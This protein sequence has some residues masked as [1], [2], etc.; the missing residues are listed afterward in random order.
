MLASEL[1]KSKYRDYLDS[2]PFNIISLSA[3]RVFPRL[4]ESLK[5]VL[6]D[7][8][9]EIQK[10]EIDSCFEYYS[11]IVSSNLYSLY[12]MDMSQVALKSVIERADL[13]HIKEV[14][15]VQHMSTNS[16]STNYVVLLKDHLHICIWLLLFSEGIVCQHFFQIMLKSNNAIFSVSLIKSYWYQRNT[17]L[18][19]VDALFSHS[20]V[21]NETMM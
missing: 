2:L 19:N 7:R 1:Q 14:W 21:S 17:G 10:A 6:T 9:F 11:S 15:E 18:D 12:T 16:T 20:G 4:V 3:N 13:V 8:M 5:S